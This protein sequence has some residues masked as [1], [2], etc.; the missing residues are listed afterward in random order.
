MDGGKLHYWLTAQALAASTNVLF[1]YLAVRTSASARIAIGGSPPIRRSRR[2]IGDFD[3]I[4]MV[5]QAARQ[6]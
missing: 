4:W 1:G 2:L 5:R 3:Q 6:V